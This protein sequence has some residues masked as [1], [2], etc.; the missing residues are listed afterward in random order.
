[1]RTAGDLEQRVAWITAREFIERVVWPYAA[2]HG[3]PGNDLCETEKVLDR[4]TGR[5]TVR[6]RFPQAEIY[7]KLYTDE[8][9]PHSQ[10][11]IEA[12]EQAGFDPQGPDRVPRSRYFPEWNLMLS[13]AVEG[14]P[15]MDY[16][17][18][19]GPEVQAFVR[20]AAR[21]LVRLHR[22]PLRIGRPE[23]LWGSLK[24]SRVLRRVAKAAARAPEER[25]DMIETIKALGDLGDASRGEL[26]IVQTH[27]RY[28]YE[29]IYVRNGTVTVIDFDRGCPSDPAKDLAEF[30]SVLRLRTFKRSGSTADAERLTRLFLETYLAELPGNEVNLPVHCGAFVLMSMLHHLKKKPKLDATAFEKVSAFYRAEFRSILDGSWLPAS[31]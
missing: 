14:R 25:R 17:G 28:H 26:P 5:V 3:A 7:G 30:I 10:R 18:D 16:L 11:M 12:L 6:Y 15:L 9:G 21:W 27:G 2:E 29:H 4:G 8:L 23:P 22:L 1:M 24:L 19:D 31:A 20:H 13:P